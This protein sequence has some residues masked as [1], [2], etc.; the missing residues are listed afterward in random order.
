MQKYVMLTVCHT[1]VHQQD[2]FPRVGNVGA[3][4]I[5]TPYA[6]ALA[7]MTCSSYLKS[8]KNIIW[9]CSILYKLLV[10]SEI[11]K[12]ACSNGGMQNIEVVGKVVPVYCMPM[13]WVINRCKCK[14]RNNAPICLDPRRVRH[15]LYITLSSDRMSPFLFQESIQFRS[16]RTWDC[17][18]LL[19]RPSWTST[20]RT[21]AVKSGARPQTML[22]GTTLFLWTLTPGL[23]SVVTDDA[24]K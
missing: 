3:L 5:K 22:D 11:Q 24:V 1:L 21:H 17:A 19:A 13:V 9:Y 4:L 14:C 12:N 18:W 15:L 6:H 20:L 10:D 7:C 2:K 23:S 16:T 8:C